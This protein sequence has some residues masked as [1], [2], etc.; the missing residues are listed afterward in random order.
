MILFTGQISSVLD[1]SSVKF[2]FFFFFFF[3]KNIYSFITAEKSAKAGLGVNRQGET[4]ANPKNVGGGAGVFSLV[5]DKSSRVSGCIRI[6]YGFW[7]GLGA[8]GGSQGP[9]QE[10]HAQ[11]RHVPYKLHL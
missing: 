5:W 8:K 10:R 2:F 11:E 1:N 4:V 3:F 9:A 6:S 7:F